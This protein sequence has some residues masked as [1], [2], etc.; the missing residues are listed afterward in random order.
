MSKILAGLW[1]LDILNFVKYNGVDVFDSILN[2]TPKDWVLGWIVIIVI[3]LAVV[4]A[5]TLLTEGEE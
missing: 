3:N 4:S 1:L 2:I 5:T